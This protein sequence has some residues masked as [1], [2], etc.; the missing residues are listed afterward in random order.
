[1][2]NGPFIIGSRVE[3]L[4]WMRVNLDMHTLPTLSQIPPECGG[5]GT[6]TS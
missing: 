5:P 2:H 3:R 4:V 6:I 1:M